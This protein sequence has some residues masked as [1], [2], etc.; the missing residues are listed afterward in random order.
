MSF[1]EGTGMKLEN[2]TRKLF[3]G[4][5]RDKDQLFQG[6]DATPFLT[7]VPGGSWPDAAVAASAHGKAGT[8]TLS[9][10]CPATL[11]AG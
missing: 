3:A 8:C 4:Q 2:L 10:Y 11:P 5:G 7:A 9:A 6:P 1:Q